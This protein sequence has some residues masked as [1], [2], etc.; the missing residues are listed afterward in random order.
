MTSM[1]PDPADPDA[2][3]SSSPG[4]RETLRLAGKDVPLIRFTG[5]LAEITTVAAELAEAGLA[6]GQRPVVVLVGGANG[7]RTGDQTVWEAM[8]RDGL[9][10]GVVRSGACL[11]DGG[12]DAGV[13]ALAG[14]ARAAVGA[15]YPAVGVAAE[16]TVH[17]PGHQPAMAGTAALGPQHTHVVVVPGRAWGMELPWISLIA[18][19]LAGARRSVT[20]VING[21]PITLADVRQS[22]QVGRPILVVAG[23]GRLADNLAAAGRG[24]S[25]ASPEEQELAASGL[26]HVVDGLR[27]P[28]GLADAITAAL[29]VPLP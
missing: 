11:V 15:D 18:G 27:S 10:A 26:I 29:Q 1:P 12:T 17:W 24:A 9:V 2:A 25:G 8:F 16:G 13:L 5:P 4:S 19:T 7:L 22:I 21:G 3:P 23:T 14:A 20:V 28:Q 6:V